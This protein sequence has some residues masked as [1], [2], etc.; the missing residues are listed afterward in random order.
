MVME[1]QEK[2]VTLY[3]ELQISKLLIHDLIEFCFKYVLMLYNSVQGL[4]GWLISI[5]QSH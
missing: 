2:T 1:S 3:Y 5:F 4:T